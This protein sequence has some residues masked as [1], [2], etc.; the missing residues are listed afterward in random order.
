MISELIY[1]LADT[2]KHVRFMGFKEIIDAPNIDCYDKSID[3]LL[4]GNS[5]RVKE[6]EI[7]TI[8]LNRSENGSNDSFISFI[9]GRNKNHYFQFSK[10]YNAWVRSYNSYPLFLNPVF[11]VS[12]KSTR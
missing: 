7:A 5:K 3:I 12:D 2:K 1:N 6:D 8:F 9:A 4:Y 11:R 10:K